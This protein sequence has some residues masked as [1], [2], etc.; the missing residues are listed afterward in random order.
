MYV[1][2]PNAL[3]AQIGRDATSAMNRRTTSD[4]E[5]KLFEQTLQA[6]RRP[7]KAVDCPS[8]KRAKAEAAAQRRPRAA[9]MAR[10]QDK[11]KRGQIAPDARI[12]LHGMTEA[13]AHR[14]LLAFL[15]GAQARGLRL[16]LVITGKGNP[17]NEDRRALDAC[18]AWRAETDGAALAERTGIR[19]VDCRD[20]A[21][22]IAA[23]AATARSMSI[24][25][26]TR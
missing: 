17:K 6:K 4:E 16:V 1:L 24:C 13:A 15:A 12:D 8:A 7:L 9:S 11:L 19:R 14:A 21:P 18:A 26:R 2:L 20:R 23:M 5:R 22:R 10:P 3:A 25:G